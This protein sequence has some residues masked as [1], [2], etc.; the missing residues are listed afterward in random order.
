MALILPFDLETLFINLFSGSAAIFVMVALILI[1]GLA[2]RFRFTWE[3]SLI[4]AGLFVV[5]M[6]G[7]SSVGSAITDMYFLTILLVGMLIIWALAKF[8]R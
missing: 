4:F 3:L 7:V 2:A 6:Y 1:I 8:W 5:F